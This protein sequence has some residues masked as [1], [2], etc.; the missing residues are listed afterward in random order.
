MLREKM[1]VVKEG[2]IIPS[3]LAYPEHLRTVFTD[4]T[5]LTVHSIYK[6]TIN[7]SAQNWFIALQPGGLPFS[8]MSFSLGVNAEAFSHLP[9]YPGDLCRCDQY[10]LHLG[11]LLF[12]HRT[13]LCFQ[14]SIHEYQLTSASNYSGAMSALESVLSETS[15][16]GQLLNAHRVVQCGNLS[17]FSHFS[18]LAQQTLTTLFSNPD[19]ETVIQE[20]K[21]LL[22]FGEGLTPAGDD[23]ICGLLAAFTVLDS[24]PPVAMLRQRLTAMISSHAHSTAKISQ[25]YLYLASNCLFS[26]LT[27]D[28]FRTVGQLSASQRILRDIQSIGHSSG[29]DFLLGMYYGLKIGGDR[30]HDLQYS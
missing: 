2:F 8:P 29:T 5:T 15:G 20:S 13:A 6:N 22:G 3:I 23:F 30:N 1:T 11:G 16:A 19:D 24:S 27:R 25:H 12:D 14:C 4:E 26:T 7:I 18:V 28:F 10:G 9:V 17:N 21:R